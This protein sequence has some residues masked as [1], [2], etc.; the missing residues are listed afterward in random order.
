MID[1]FPS[2]Y[3]TKKL[4]FWTEKEINIRNHI[5]NVL[6][7]CIKKALKNINMAWDF[8][9]VEGTLLTPN[10]FISDEYKNEGV[11]SIKEKPYTL[12]A[13]T[14]KSSYLA[15]AH[16]IKN[17]R[18]KVP[19]CVWQ[20][21]KSFR[22]EDNDGASASK[23]RYYEFYQ[24]EFQCIYSKDSLADYSN[25]IYCVQKDLSDYFK[26][27]FK[28]EESDRLPS[29]SKKTTD[30]MCGD[31]SNGFI[32]VA[33]VSERIDFNIDGKEYNVLEVAFGL[34]RLVKII[35]SSM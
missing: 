22:L 26:L 9:R 3:E 21:G 34:D 4:I 20:A 33:S 11:F 16:L 32:E 7:Q 35:L 23:M 6:E 15:A 18:Y 5:T 1:N 31:S 2:F 19:L 30:I 12:R 29:Y 8:V 28:I 27:V 10:L 24:C 17:T 13:E 25:V 14:T